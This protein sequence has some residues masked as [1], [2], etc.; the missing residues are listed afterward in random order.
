MLRIMFAAALAVTPALPAAAQTV[1]SQNSTEP[2]FGRQMDTSTPAAQGQTAAR[3]TPDGLAWRND[4]LTLSLAGGAFTISPLLRLD[5]DGVSFFDQH[6]PNG[7]DSGTQVRRGR[8]GAR[9]TFLQDFEYNVTWEFG[10]YPSRANTLFEAQVAWNGLGWAT[11]RAGTFTL[12]HLP[13]YASSSY[14]LLFL[15][16]AS[17]TNIVASLASGDTREALGF[18]ARGS[19]WNASL[20]GTAGVTSALHDSKQR[21]VVGRGVALLVDEPSLQFQL[22]FDATA[23][24]SPGTSPGPD[25]IRLRDYP[26]LRGDNANRFLD[27]SGIRT[28]TAYAFGPEAAGR[29]GPV[30]LEAL[31]QHVVVDVTNGGSRNFDGWYIQAA[32]PLLGPS[33]QRV[34]NTG[35]WARPRTQGMVDPLNGHWGAVEAVARYSTVDLR[36]GPTRGGAQS[37]WTGG[38]SWYLSPN[39]KVQAE[40]ENGQI[41]LDTRNRD[42]QAFGVRLAISL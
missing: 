9:G 37:I 32:V 23:Q 26:E 21:G 17:I 19:R 4:R 27:T 36:D 11:V 15:E 25:S 29:V 42:F 10:S 33:R 22:G 39:L 20:Y 41:K 16:R 2:S 1:R 18:E 34:R 12:Q 13:E 5:L 30:Y 31:Y 24:F 3:A 6:A 8:L 28:D 7:F 35:T 38:L 14:D 40:Y